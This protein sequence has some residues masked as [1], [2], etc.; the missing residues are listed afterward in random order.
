SATLGMR[1]MTSRV[2]RRRNS[3]SSERGDGGTWL[4]RSAPVTWES[5]ASAMA[6][7]ASCTGPAE[8]TPP[9][10]NVKESKATRKVVIDTASRTRVRLTRT[11]FL[12]NGHR[13]GQVVEA[14]RG[15]LDLQGRLLFLVIDR[16]VR[17]IAQAHRERHLVHAREHPVAVRG[18][19]H[20]EGT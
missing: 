3:A 11:L 1:P 12:L 20:V 10:D 14:G 5:M 19:L 9:Q 15:H 16:Q 17:W 7:E 2:M 4:I 13:E 18:G 6:R 8:Q